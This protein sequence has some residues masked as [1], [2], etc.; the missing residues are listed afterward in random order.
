MDFIGEKDRYKLIT[1]YKEK[2]AMT[3]SD[4]LDS[5]IEQLLHFIVRDFIDTWYKNL[6]VDELFQESLLRSSRRSIGALAQW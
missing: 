5:V 2:H 3:G 6:T 1:M 4:D